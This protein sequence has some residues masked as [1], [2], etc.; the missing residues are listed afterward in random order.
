M[1]AVWPGMVVREGNPTV[2][3]SALRR[4][5]DEY[6]EGAAASRGRPGLAIVSS[7]LSHGSSPRPDRNPPVFR[8]L[9]SQT[10]LSTE[11]R[12]KHWN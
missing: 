1:E 7:P 8:S 6:R 4:I 2:Q 11:C 9:T 12:R 3:I 10:L 5:L